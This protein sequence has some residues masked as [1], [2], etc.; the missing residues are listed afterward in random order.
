MLYN[1]MGEIL[2]KNENKSS[3]PECDLNL[4]RLYYDGFQPLFM[5]ANAGSEALLEMNID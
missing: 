4:F 5:V 2:L 3:P 1:E